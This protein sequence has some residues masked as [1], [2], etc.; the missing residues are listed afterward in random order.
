MAITNTAFLPY[1]VSALR[2][3]LHSVLSGPAGLV[4]AGN[5]QPSLCLR[6]NSC[7]ETF[8]STCSGVLLEIWGL[9]P[10]IPYI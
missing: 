1:S 2:C 4:P 5:E 7:K 6:L 8:V 3:D 9:R 10:S